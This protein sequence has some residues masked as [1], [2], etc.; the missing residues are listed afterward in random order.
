[1]QHTDD[2]RR[3]ERERVTFAETWD[4]EPTWAEEAM[5]MA[6]LIRGEPTNPG[7]DR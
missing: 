4:D 3:D 5:T 7:R 2:R 1:M 6:E